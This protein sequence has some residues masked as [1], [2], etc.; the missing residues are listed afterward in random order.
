MG[1]YAIINDDFQLKMTRLFEKA[2]EKK[3]GFV[4]DDH[5]ELSFNQLKDVAIEM[6]NQVVCNPHFQFDWYG[7]EQFRE[8]IRWLSDDGNS[9]TTLEF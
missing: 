3:L 9:K 1:V 4:Y 6:A 8:L 5:P 7:Y 2:V